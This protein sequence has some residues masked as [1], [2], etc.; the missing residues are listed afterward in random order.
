MSNQKLWDAAKTHSIFRD[1]PTKTIDGIE[2]I[3]AEGVGILTAN[4]A[5]QQCH[6]ILH[7][8]AF[9]EERIGVFRQMAEHGGFNIDHQA[10]DLE[11]LASEAA[12]KRL[13]VL[14]GLNL[15]NGGAA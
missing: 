9:C 10:S 11:Q 12:T 8:Q 14:F 1:V 15:H 4:A 3:S 2:C 5:F 7:A 13:E 6:T